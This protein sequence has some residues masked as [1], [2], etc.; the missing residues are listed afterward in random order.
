MTRAPRWAASYA[1]PRG[2]LALLVLT[3][4]LLC[5][6]GRAGSPASS[7]ERAVPFPAPS[8]A[9]AVSQ[10]DAPSDA[11][12]DSTPCGRKSTVHQS[13]TQR[14]EGPPPSPPALALPAV[15]EPRTTWSHPA[16]ALLPGGP[17]PPPPVTSRS[18]LRL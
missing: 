16:E 12:G 14:A 18:V 6:F 3:V 9:V 17:S 2:V 4:L 15:A 5:V 10:V 8:P 1:A 13:V 7:A 11:G